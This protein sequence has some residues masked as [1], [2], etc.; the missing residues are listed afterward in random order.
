MH[1]RDRSKFQLLILFGQQF[2]QF[3]RCF[4]LLFD[5][6]RKI[7]RPVEV[8]ILFLRPLGGVRRNTEQDIVDFFHR[9]A[10]RYGNQVDGQHEVAPD[11]THFANHAILEDRRIL[12]E[13]DHTRI[14]ISDLDVIGTHR[15]GFGCDHIHERM[16]APHTPLHAEPKM[17][18]LARMEKV[19]EHPQPFLG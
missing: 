18:L 12:L 8:L 15:H 19:I 11:I 7:G 4:L 9:F 14:P 2:Q 17:L 16:P 5:L 6:E 10:R 3:L 1:E 13:I